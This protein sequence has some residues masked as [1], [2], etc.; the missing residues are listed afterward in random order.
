[1][2]KSSEAAVELDNLQL[3]YRCAVELVAAVQDCMDSSH[4]D[5]KC[6]SEALLGAVTALLLYGVGVLM[7]D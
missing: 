2:S 1:M 6:Y 7:K 4:N 5:P 3:Q